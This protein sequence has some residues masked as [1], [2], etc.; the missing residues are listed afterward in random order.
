MKIFAQACSSG[1]NFIRN[2]HM[3]NYSVRL[4]IVLMLLISASYITSAQSLIWTD[5]F[6]QGL[7]P[8]SAQC[9]NWTNFLTELGENDFVSATISGTF[10]TAGIKIT[11]PAAASELARLLSLG[12][13]G[14]VTSDGHTWQVGTGCGGSCVASGV[15]LVVDGGGCSCDDRYVIRAH[16]GNFNWGGLNGGCDA[17]SQTMKLEF[18]SGAN[19]T[20]SGPTSICK[21]E[22]VI[23]TASS[24]KCSGPYTYLWSNGET[25]ESITVSQSGTYSVKVSDATGCSGTSTKTLVT[26]NSLTVDAGE[27]AT[28]CDN[29]VQLNA[30]GSFNGSSI[31]PSVA[32][33]CMFNAPGG[34]DNCYFTTDVCTDGGEYVKNVEY[35]QSIAIT[36]PQEI[37]FMLFYTACSNNS[38]FTFKLNNQEIGFFDETN[39]LCN[40]FPASATQ[41]P[42]TINF[43]KSQ[44]EQYWN[45]SGANVLSVSIVDNTGDLGVYLAGIISEVVSQNEFY[46]WSP[47]TGLSDVSIKNPVA[48]PTVS[49]TY[50]VTYSVGNGCSATDQITVKSCGSVPPVAVCKPVVISADVNC[51][52]NASAIDF[53]NG[54]TSQEGSILK[55]SVLPMGPYAVGITNVELTVTNEQGQTSS[56]STTVTVADDVLPTIE[57]PENISATNNAGGLCS[58]TLVLTTPQA[59]DNCGVKSITSDHPDNVF[60]VGETIVTWTV[61]DNHG[62]TNSTTQT[63]TVINQHPV[64]HSVVASGS[65]IATNS[66]TSLTTSYTDNNVIRATIDWND[67]SGLQEVTNPGNLFKVSHIYNHAGLYSPTITLTDACGAAAAYVSDKIVVYDSHGGGYVTGNGWY[68]S[69]QGAYLSRPSAMGKASF[70][71]VVKYKKQGNVPK[72]NTEFEFNIGKLKFRSSDYKWLVVKDNTAVFKGSGKLNGTSG[73]EILISV[74]DDDKNDGDNDDND[75]DKPS[76][77]A[78]KTKKSDRIRVKI[79]DP[80][81]SVV[82]DT[83]IGAPDEAEAMTKIGG[84]FIRVNNNKQQQLN[85]VLDKTFAEY[86]KEAETDVYP[87]PF[88]ESLTVQFYSSSREGLHLQLSDVSGKAVYDQNHA[89]NEDGEYSIQLAP[90]EGKPGLYI[91]KINQGRIVEY[92]KVMRK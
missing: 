81:G 40:C 37:R 53:N 68:H 59:S 52:G 58:A 23:L 72:G 57:T 17:E 89:Y 87:N 27:D 32:K 78:K 51:T 36:N 74:V 60:P 45:A 82:Y 66:V 70:S 76:K 2:S 15:E 90:S 28:N 62:K 35:S 16:S 20:A 77:S 61:T 64:I 86:S 80:S 88:K 31:P 29:P 92:I 85:Q 47:A 13:P 33:F 6:T 91:L 26:L 71:F 21:G 73:Y 44:F 34:I 9:N 67:H 43:T 63:V 14:S 75:N 79:S 50:T 8:T 69:P 56:C 48:N 49:T 3:R 83:Q 12:L 42:K 38:K 65:V 39:R 84:G 19:I 54:S 7:A 1:L 41:Y 18:E 25:S 46:S 55:Y 5:N 10:L 11:D 30:L 22:S 24:A 4:V